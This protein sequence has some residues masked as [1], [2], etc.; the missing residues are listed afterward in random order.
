MLSSRCPPSFE[1]T[2]RGSCELRDLYQF[3]DSLESTRRRRHA[4]GIAAAPRRLH[5][6]ARSTSAGTCSS[7]H[8]CRATAR[9]PAPAA[10]G[11]TADS[12]TAV[13]RSIGIH[14]QDAGRAAPTLWNVAFLKRFF[15]D[16][17]ADSLEAQAAGPLFSPKEMGNTPQRLLREPER[18]R[19]LTAGCSRRRSPATPAGPSRREQVYTALAAF[20]TSLVSLNSRYDRYAHGYRRR[21]QRARDRRA[22]RV[23]L[24]RRTLRRVPHAAAVHQRAGRGDRRAG[25]AGQDVR[26]RRR[27]HLPC[28]QAQGRLQGADAAQHRAHGAVHALGRVRHA[29]RARSISTTRAAATRCRRA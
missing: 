2:A 16:A 20:Q 3:Y 11:P 7:I 4:H 10:T 14:G 8:C 17:R 6:A 29:A 12:P 26:R 25:A 21:A 22:Q 18:Q 5:A 1:K 19:R 9:C 23:P 28:R 15:W 24:V 13:P 27:K